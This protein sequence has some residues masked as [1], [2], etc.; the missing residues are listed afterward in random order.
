MVS[1]G[2][3]AFAAV[4][5]CTTNVIKQPGSSGAASGGETGRRESVACKS[6]DTTLPIEAFDINVDD[7][8][9]NACN[10]GSILDDDGSFTALDWTGPGT[11]K[12][13]GRDVAGCV[14]AEFSD[15]VTLSS[16]NMKIRPIGKGCAHE[17]TPGTD[18]CGTGW[19]I[20][21]FA[22]PSIEK[23][24]YLQQLSLTTA[25]FNEYRVVV[26]KRFEAKFIAICREPT[27][28]TGDDIAIDAVSGFCY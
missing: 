13:A 4:A 16:L 2:L 19:K 28:V 1:F 14:A 5:G 22:G 3:I 12:L 6:G 21:I 9:G 24:D 18:G 26:Y 8:T 7:A 11:H 17:C 25:E 10:T 27:P 15:G 20:D 23:L